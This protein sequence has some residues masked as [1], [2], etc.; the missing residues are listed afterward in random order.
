MA[1][2]IPIATQCVVV[3]SNVSTV[4]TNGQRIERAPCPDQ[5]AFDLGPKRIQFERQ[6]DVRSGR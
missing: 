2:L 4:P 3:A 1:N 6:L 5:A